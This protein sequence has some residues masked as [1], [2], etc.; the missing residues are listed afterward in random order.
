MEDV[1]L[2]VTSRLRYPIEHRMGKQLYNLVLLLGMLLAIS[3]NARAEQLVAPDFEIPGLDKRIRLSDYRGKI[4]YL[5]FW[6]SWCVPCRQS[7]PWME[8]MHQQY[9]S[10]GLEI[11]AI[12]LDQ[13]RELVDSFMQ[14]YSSSSTIG[15]DI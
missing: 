4:V 6:A 13:E 15:F 2:L 1:N 9:R 11:I 10:Q 5:D 14:E 12:N 8:R 3:L 7:F